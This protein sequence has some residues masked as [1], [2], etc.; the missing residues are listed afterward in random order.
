MFFFFKK[1]NNYFIKSF[2][3]LDFRN[4]TMLFRINK[5]NIK[6][7]FF[8]KFLFIDLY[9]NCLK[10]NDLKQFFFFIKLLELITK[11]KSFVVNLKIDDNLFIKNNCINFCKTVTKKFFMVKFLFTSRIRV[12]F[13]NLKTVK[14]FFF[15][16][17]LVYFLQ[18][19]SKIYNI[20]FCSSTLSLSFLKNKKENS[21]LY[22]FF[23]KK[24]YNI[25]K[26]IFFFKSYYNL[27]SFYKVNNL[28]M[29]TVFFSF[30]FYIHK[31]N[32]F[33]FNLFVS[34]LFLFNLVLK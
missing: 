19:F 22:Y 20:N 11:K 1:N 31:N 3:W 30:C 18:F 14:F 13:C 5:F 27:L 7:R 12:G 8:F 32:N 2:S 23:F 33:F 28:S 6:K 15:N 16:W 24:N 4:T 26:F 10:Y 34:S 21:L 25:V 9:Y 17:F 29:Y